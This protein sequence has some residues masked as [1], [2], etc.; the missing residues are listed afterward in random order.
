M[1][2]LPGMTCSPPYFFTPRRRPAESR[3][4]RDEPPAFLCAMVQTPSLISAYSSAFALRARGFFVSPV[5]AASAAGS[6]LAFA[7]FF[8]AAPPFWALAFFAGASAVSPAAALRE[9]LG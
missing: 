2:M 1:M 7:A 8:F 9:R 5:A 3:P 4:L 6:A